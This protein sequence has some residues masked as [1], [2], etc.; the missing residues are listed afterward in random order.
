MSEVPVSSNITHERKGGLYHQTVLESVPSDCCAL[1]SEPLFLWAVWLSWFGVVRDE[2]CLKHQFKAERNSLRWHLR[3][4]A[5][6]S[7]ET[8]PQAV[9]CLCWPWA[10]LS[11]NLLCP[12]FMFCVWGLGLAYTGKHRYDLVLWEKTVEQV[13]WALEAFSWHLA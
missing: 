7:G 10:L 4:L 8:E 9:S 2:W 13:G 1:C 11:H 6:S 12:F 3:D 5:A